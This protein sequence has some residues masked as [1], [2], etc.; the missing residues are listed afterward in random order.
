MQTGHQSDIFCSTSESPVKIQTERVLTGL[1]LLWP[2]IAVVTV[3]PVFSWISS[4]WV[5]EKNVSIMKKA[6]LVW[7]FCLQLFPLYLFLM[8]LSWTGLLTS[9]EIRACY[10]KSFALQGAERTN[11]V[12]CPCGLMFLCADLLSSYKKKQPNTSGK[13]V[14]SFHLQNS[15]NAKWS[16]F[17]SVC[18]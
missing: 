4:S 14:E 13:C 9:K 5:I 6:K 11:Y 16:F 18:I 2:V 15:R 7:L 3:H 1:V 8:Y 17:K 10:C 12:A